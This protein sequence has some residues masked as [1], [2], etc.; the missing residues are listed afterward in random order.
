ML[1]ENPS[2]RAKFKMKKTDSGVLVTKVA[3][4][5]AAKKAGL[6]ENDVLAEIGGS[7]IGND[8]TIAFR[9]GERLVTR[10]HTVGSSNPFARLA[11]CWYFSSCMHGWRLDH[12]NCALYVMHVLYVLYVRKAPNCKLWHVLVIRPGNMRTS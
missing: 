8:G 6:R 1:C 9:N 5:G 7:Q 10:H 12:I 3:P 2:L 11:C 4:L